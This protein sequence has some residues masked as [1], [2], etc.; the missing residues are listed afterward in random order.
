[1]KNVCL[2]LQVVFSLCASYAWSQTIA[3]TAPQFKGGRQEF[4]KFLLN[5]INFTAADLE[6]GA[7][8]NITATIYISS[9]GKVKFINV[10]AVKGMSNLEL[11]THVKRQLTLMPEWIPGK[12]NGVAIDTFVTQQIYMTQ[13]KN[14]RTNNDSTICEI[15]MYKVDMSS[16]Q[17]KDMMKETKESV[18]K[19][20]RIDSLYNKGLEESNK[21]NLTDA[22]NF[23][24]Q[25]KEE[26]LRGANLYYNLG[27]VYIKS[28]NKEMACSSFR[29]AARL[30][31][32]EAY[33]LYF[34]M[35]K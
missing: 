28:G 29:E 21:N 25:A 7:E 24:N 17:Y 11:K 15:I 4:H 30:G 1:M 5:N 10:I 16:S 14:S 12:W 19:N 6:S 34:K 31:D 3:Y 2:Y 26:G 22:I 8:P 18:A 13:G 35:C 32:E 27:V 20:K 9:E 23:F 33:K